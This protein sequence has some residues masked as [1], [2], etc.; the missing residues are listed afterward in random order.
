MTNTM[1]ITR[2]IP[3]SGK[4]TWARE[5]VHESPETRV[6]VNRDN[7][8]YM[9]GFPAHGDTTHEKSV[10]DI[11]NTMIH[12]AINNGKDIVISDTNMRER[13]IKNFI[14]IAMKNDYE[15]SI[16]DFPVDVQVA[17][18]R[19]AQREDSVGEDVIRTMNKKFPYKNWKSCE[20]MI[21]EIIA[22]DQDSVRTP[23]RNDPTN[24]DAIMVDIDGTIAIND[25]HRSFYDYDDSVK[26][27]TVNT[28]VV[29]AVRIAHKAGYKI[30][31][32]SG[33]KDSCKQA[34]MEWM[35]EHN[36]PYDEVHF[37]HS[38]D[39]RADWI[40]KDEMVREFIQDKYHIVFCYDDRNQVVNHHRAM[41]YTVFQ[42]A[43][44]D[45]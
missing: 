28:P 25:G 18:K 4:S 10:S 8:R 29:D 37:R 22:K 12:A 41:G 30:I 14:K 9:M 27:D 1:I 31:I 24:P 23:Y 36:I 45:F 32:M 16:K 21:H 39:N 44:G 40:V 3:A 13:Y 17:I 26:G 38:D 33:R 5:W 42:V 20:D 2:G 35:D 11:H 43:P 7:I 19:D 15:V 34:S 6:E